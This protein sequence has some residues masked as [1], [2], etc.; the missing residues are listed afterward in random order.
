VD[1]N[2]AFIL[3]GFIEAHDTRFRKTRVYPLFQVPGQ[4]TTF[5]VEASGDTE[6][7]QLFES[8]PTYVKESL[9]TSPNL[10]FITELKQLLLGIKQSK[11]TLPA[12]SEI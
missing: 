8:I 2:E 9:S 5:V 10:S 1:K 4:S 3:S 12:F 7:P 6:E 11:L